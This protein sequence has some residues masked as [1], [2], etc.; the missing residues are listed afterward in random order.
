[1]KKRSLHVFVLNPY[2]FNFETTTFNKPAITRL[3]P[4]FLS[5]AKFHSCN[6][7]A[8]VGAGSFP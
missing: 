6:S 8:V 1:M 4:F 5:R 7:E 3:N 2:A